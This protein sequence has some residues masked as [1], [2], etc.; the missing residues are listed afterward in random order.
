LLITLEAICG[1]AEFRDAFCFFVPANSISSG[2]CGACDMS[3]KIIVVSTFLCPKKF[4]HHIY[5]VFADNKDLL[6]K[7]E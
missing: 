1:M 2:L 6:C 7:Y 3:R 5:Y 4:L